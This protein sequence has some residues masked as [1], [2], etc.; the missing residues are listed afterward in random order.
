MRQLTPR[1]QV[2]RTCAPSS[3]TVKYQWPEA[4]A[5]KLEI[6]PSTQT[7]AKRFSIAPRTCDVSSETLRGLRSAASNSD[8][9]MGRVTASPFSREHTRKSFGWRVSGC[10]EAAATRLRQKVYPRSHTKRREGEARQGSRDLEEK[11]RVV[12]VSLRV[13]SWA[14][15]PTSEHSIARCLGGRLSVA[16]RGRASRGSLCRARS[17]SGGRAVGCPAC[18][19]RGW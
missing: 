5:R 11:L 15:F 1:K 16:R 10:R 8:M 7:E 18:G 9:R 6:S 12:F 4:A 19:V 2:A 17:S 13:I 14:D 3:R